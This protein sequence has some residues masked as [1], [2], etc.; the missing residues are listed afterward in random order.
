MSK[1]WHWKA[2]RFHIQSEQT[3]RHGLAVQSRITEAD[4]R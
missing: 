3:P 2:G 1:F 4:T